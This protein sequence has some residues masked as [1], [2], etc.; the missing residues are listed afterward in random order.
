MAG[1]L[2]LLYHD[3]LQS[4]DEKSGFSGKDADSYK[5]PIYLFERHLQDISASQY[6]AIFTFDDGGASCFTTI[7]PLLEQ[8]QYTGL[9]FIPTASI[10]K[11]GFLAAAQIKEL[12]KR[13]HIIGS[14]GHTHRP[15]SHL[16]YKDI[17]REWQDSISI[18]KEIT[19]QHA[20]EASLPG[21]WYSKSAAKAA[22]EAGI[23]T[24][25]TSEPASDSFEIYDCKVQGRFNINPSSHIPNL[26]SNIQLQKQLHNEWK[27]KE[28]VKKLLGSWY[29]K[30][31]RF[32]K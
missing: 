5:L 18:L 15:L 13:G 24:L 25:Y 21:G 4:A 1:P 27:R 26:L 28:M 8:Y 30:I 6:P 7:A 9:F 11:P 29:L 32:V 23:K 2:I 19:G 16:P 12:Y 31:R 20:T 22:A 3:V 10:G 14:H 17:L